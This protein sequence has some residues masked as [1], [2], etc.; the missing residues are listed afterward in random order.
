MR[1]CIH[2]MLDHQKF[3]S[4]KND[5]LY[6][7]HIKR[8]TEDVCN[9]VEV[10]RETFVSPF[11]DSHLV[12]ISN[13]LVATE[14]VCKSLMIVETHGKTTMNTFITERLEKGATIDFF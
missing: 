5:D 13:G 14:G 8:D 3:K 6:I 7:C 10:L 4:N 9:M 12:C 1:L 11:T 2:E